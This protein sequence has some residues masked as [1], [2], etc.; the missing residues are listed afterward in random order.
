MSPPAP[1]AAMWAR[2]QAAADRHSA[3]VAAHQP[4]HQVMGAMTAAVNCVICASE[5]VTFAVVGTPA[6]LLTTMGPSASRVPGFTSTLVG[7]GSPHWAM[8]HLALAVWA[9]S[10]DGQRKM[11]LPIQSTLD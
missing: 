2:R 5:M 11:P 6:A 1:N 9:G 4:A 3:L 8:N 10:G 7:A